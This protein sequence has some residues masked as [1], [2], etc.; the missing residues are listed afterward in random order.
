MKF[1][2]RFIHNIINVRVYWKLFNY[3][4]RELCTKRAT[5]QLCTKRFI[6]FLLAKESFA[7]I[8]NT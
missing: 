7:F 6:N 3:T 1:N 2:C 4:A 8:K 5:V